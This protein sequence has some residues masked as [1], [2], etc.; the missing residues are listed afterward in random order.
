MWA[1]SRL[2]SID[3]SIANTARL[4][5]IEFSGEIH[6]RM[7]TKAKKGINRPRL[8]RLARPAGHVFHLM[9]E[10]SALVFL[11]RSGMTAWADRSPTIK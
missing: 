2:G 7:M 8:A 5:Q 9:D 10:L 11:E 4:L 3:G 6:F 1:A